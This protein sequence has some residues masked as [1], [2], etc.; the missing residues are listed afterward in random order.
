MDAVGDLL[1]ERQQRPVPLGAGGRAR[2]PPPRRRPRRLP[3]SRRWRKP[4]RYARPRAVAVRL[5]P[6]GSIRAP[7]AG[8]GRRARA[9]GRRRRSR[10]SRSPPRGSAAQPSKNAVLLPAK[11]DK[12]KPT[13]PPVSPPRATPRRP[14]SACPRPA[15]RPRHRRRGPAAGAGGTAG[16]GSLKIDQADFKYPVYI[17]RLVLIIGLNWFKPAQSVQTNPVVHFQIERDGTI[18]DAA[19]RDLER[20]AVRRPRRAARRPRVLPAA[21][22]ARRVRGAAISESRSSSNENRRRLRCTDVL[23]SPPRP[24]SWRSRGPAPR[25]PDPRAHAGAGRRHPD[26]D[27]GRRGTAPR[28]RRA[29]ALRARDRRA[30]GQGRRPV[31]GDAALGPRVRRAPSRSPTRPTTPPGFR[32]PTTPG[33]RGPLARHGRRGPRRHARRG[34]GRPR[35]RRGPRLGPEVPQ[36]HPRA[37]VLGRRLL[38][39]AHRAHARQRPRQVLHRASRAS[40]SPRSSSSSEQ[41]GDKEI[42]AMDFDGRNVRQLTSHK[43][44]A[45]SPTRGRPGRSPTPPTCASSRRSGR[46]AST[47]ATR[48]R[49]RRASS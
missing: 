42:V 44:I 13:P 38:R 35:L 43:S 37:A 18:T 47:A 4:V 34:R 23:C 15:T 29:G 20:T 12:K 5:L 27:Q 22:A 30:A 10:R 6:A 14:R 31:H 48:G 41:G 45:I 39:R 16:I 33:G 8:P 3:R 17:E 9:S 21:A 11:E 49:S 7:R 25:G 2:A 32:D 36:A 26:R 19:D 46:W 24:C 40:S 1:A 28:R